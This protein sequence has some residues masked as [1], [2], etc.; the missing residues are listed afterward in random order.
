[1]NVIRQHL[2]LSQLNLEQLR[3][4]WNRLQRIQSGVGLADPHEKL[5]ESVLELSKVEQSVLELLL[6][7]DHAAEEILP[8]LVDRVQGLAD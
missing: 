6:P 7:I 4:S 3:I 1:M 8:P 5:V 2:Q